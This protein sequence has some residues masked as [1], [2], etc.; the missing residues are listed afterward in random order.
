MIVSPYMVKSY[1]KDVK[2]HLSRWTLIIL[3]EWSWT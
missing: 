1:R 2:I 3:R